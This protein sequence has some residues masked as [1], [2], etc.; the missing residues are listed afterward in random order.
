MSGKFARRIGLSLGLG[1]LAL[2][3]ISSGVAFADDHGGRDRDGG[4]RGRDGGDRGRDRD[5]DDAREV[6]VVAP[7][8]NVV[9]IVPRAPAPAPAPQCARV[10]P[11]AAT[12]DS[13]FNQ[14]AAGGGLSLTQAALIGNA[15]Y[16]SA[17]EVQE[18]SFDQLIN[19]TQCAGVSLD[20]LAS[21]LSGA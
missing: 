21:I 17:D 20:T 8:N 9:T 10:D 3:C 16:L 5:R 14:F 18:L 4:N 6:R 1:L 13:I 12:V 19:M 15:L 2:S 11:S 7:N